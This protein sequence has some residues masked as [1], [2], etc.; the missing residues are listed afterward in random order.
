MLLRCVRFV[1][2]GIC[3]FVFAVV[4]PAVLCVYMVSVV[5][6]RGVVCVVLCYYCICVCAML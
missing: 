6:S 4:L 5:E 2:F 3:C 1:D